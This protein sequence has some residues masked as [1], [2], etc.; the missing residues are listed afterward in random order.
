VYEINRQSIVTA[1]SNA[2]VQKNITV[3]ILIER[4]KGNTQTASLDNIPN[5]TVVSDDNPKLMH[6]KFIIFDYNGTSPIANMIWTG[7]L[8]L[9]DNGIDNNAQNVIV[10]QDKNLATEYSNEFHQ[11]FYD[12]NFD[13]NKTAHSTHSFTIDDST[14]EVYFSPKDSPKTRLIELINSA[15]YSIYFCIFSFSDPDIINAIKTKYQEG[16]D[17]RGVC[18]G[19]ASANYGSSGIYTVATQINMP[20]YKDKVQNQPDSWSYMLHHK[21]MVI[22]NGHSD[23][24]PIVVTGSYNW[25]LTGNNNNDENMLVVHNGEV[26]EKYFQEFKSRYLEAGGTLPE[27]ASIS[28]LTAYPDNNRIRI[29]WQSPEDNFFKSVSI[30]CSESGYLDTPNP[31]YFVTNVAGESGKVQDVLLDIAVKNNTRYFFSVFTYN[32]ANDYSG[33]YTSCIYFIPENSGSISDNLITSKSSYKNFEI[34]FDNNNT[35]DKIYVY[36]MIGKLVAELTSFDN[37]KFEWD[38]SMD[39]TQVGS[40]LYFIVYYINGNRNVKK[41]LIAR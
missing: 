2:A 14:V 15:N 13:G 11:M 19:W 25:T 20:V 18:D 31:I 34:Y 21:F 36:N 22:D 10:L 16:I 39:N 27:V 8:N 6:N 23:S 33:S 5:I 37:R 28:N 30:Y 9:T 40:G 4:D 3:N 24:D 26:S 17:V 7:S 38:L 35:P 12:K 1:L 32:D 41:I 29:K